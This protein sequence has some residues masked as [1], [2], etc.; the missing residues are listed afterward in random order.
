MFSFSAF[1]DLPADSIVHSLLDL[2][3]YDVDKLPDAHKTGEDML[4]RHQEL[5]MKHWGTKDSAVLPDDV[6]QKLLL[7]VRPSVCP[8]APAW[9]HSR[10]LTYFY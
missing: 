1:T 9:L 2:D 6:I 8:M 10:F 7:G 4:R 3:K 5:M